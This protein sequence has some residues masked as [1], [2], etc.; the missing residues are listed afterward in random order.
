MK[1][2]LVIALLTVASTFTVFAQNGKTEQEILKIHNGLDQAFLKQD[3]AYFEGV[4]ADDYIYANPS[5]KKMNRT[6]TLE[7]LRKEWTNTSY[8]VLSGGT[9]DVKV[10]VS[11]NMA[12]VTANWT[13][14][15][16][17]TGIPNPEPHKDTGR[18][19]G[20]YE[21][22]GGKWLLIAE[23]FSEAQHDRKLM[24]EQ[25]LKMG[26]E[27]GEMIK[28]QDVAAVERILADEYIYTNEKGKVQNKTENLASYKTNPYKFET[29]EVSDQ[30]VRVIGNGA[31]VETGIV[32][33]KGTNKDNKPFE[34]SERYTTTWVWRGG[35]WQIVADHVS[36]IKQ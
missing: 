29:F 23:H 3:I 31:A 36:E 25:V 11:G 10:R 28:N 17:S 33:Y 4:L 6:E 1:K 18:Y 14:T 21:K 26:R 15:T 9:D 5:A 30:Q 24:E 16:A 27:Y 8:K 19:T 35:R 12:L 13:S 7:D 34:G 2:L 22:R 20:V 32:R